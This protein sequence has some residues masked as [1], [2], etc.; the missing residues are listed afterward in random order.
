[1]LSTS[2]RLEYNQSFAR[3][4]IQST[5]GQ[6]D[7]QQ[8]H[9]EISITQRPAELTID[10]GP[11]Q[12]DL[13]LYTARKALGFKNAIDMLTDIASQARQVVLEGIGRV[14]SEGNQMAAIQNHRNAIADI[15]VQRQERGPMPIQDYDPASYKPVPIGYQP[16]ETTLSWQVHGTEIHATPHTPIINYTPGKVDVYLDQKNWLQFE[17]KGQYMNRQ[18]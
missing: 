9:A 2:L 5:A 14:V 3:I 7:I 16:H 18:F 10:Q 11:G 8:P 13:D 17:V 4:G 12:L 1:M 6:W 15:A